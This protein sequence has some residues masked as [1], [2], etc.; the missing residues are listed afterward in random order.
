MALDESFGDIDTSIE[1]NLCLLQPFDDL[2]DLLL[3]SDRFDGL[4]VVEANLT[5]LHVGRLLQVGPHGVHHVYIVHFAALNAV[6][7]DQLG[8]VVDHRRRNVIQSLA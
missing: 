6:L 2:I 7:F 5:D 4:V 1:S 3:D 8:A